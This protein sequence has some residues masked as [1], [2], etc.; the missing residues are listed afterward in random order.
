MVA[1]PLAIIMMKACT[2]DHTMVP[3]IANSARLWKLST[4]RLPKP[5]ARE[6]LRWSARSSHCFMVSSGARTAGLAVG[7]WIL[8]Q[9][10][11]VVRA[12]E[13]VL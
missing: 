1:P 4:S 2:A 6:L 10:R 8:G 13:G 3:P 7:Y 11:G 12:L 9:E 5:W